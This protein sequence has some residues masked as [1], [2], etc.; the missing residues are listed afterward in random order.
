M[1]MI[2]KCFLD[3]WS[4]TQ[5]IEIN[6]HSLP[7]KRVADK[8]MKKIMIVGLLLFGR[9]EYMVFIIGS[10]S[11]CRFLAFWKL[12]KI[13]LGLKSL[14]RQLSMK[15]S[16]MAVVEY[17]NEDGKFQ[18]NLYQMNFVKYFLI[19]HKNFWFRTLK[20]L[21]FLNF[22]AK[23]QNQFHLLVIFIIKMMN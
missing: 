4:Q 14:S 15:I 9:L 2:L 3:K 20:K 5:L 23:V 8:R 13:A 11:R 16:M 22:N 7:N 10:A 19:L 1:N 21:L 6:K 18:S 17:H 12:A